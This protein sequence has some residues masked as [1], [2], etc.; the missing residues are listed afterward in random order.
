MLPPFATTGGMSGA[1]LKAASRNTA[2]FITP[3]ITPKFPPSRRPR[4]I[5]RPCIQQDT[6]SALKTAGRIPLKSG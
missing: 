5:L 1:Q 6:G 4:D 2:L 3:G